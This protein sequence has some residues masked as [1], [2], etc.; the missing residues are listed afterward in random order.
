MHLNIWIVQFFWTCSAGELQL[1]SKRYQCYMSKSVYTSWLYERLYQTIWGLWDKQHKIWWS[2]SLELENE[3]TKQKNIWGCAVKV[4]Q[5]Y[6]TSV[7]GLLEATLS[8]TSITHPNLQPNWQWMCCIV[9]NVV[10]WEKEN[11]WSTKQKIY[12]FLLLQFWS[13]GP[14]LCEC[15][16]KPVGHLFKALQRVNTMTSGLCVCKSAWMSKLVTVREYNIRDK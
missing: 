13:L 5:S 10:A 3:K 8:R 14:M 12:F 9:D 15:N 6:Q 1:K 7:A 2:A 16:A 11:T 4:K